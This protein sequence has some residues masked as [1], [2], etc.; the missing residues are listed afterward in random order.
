MREP[1]GSAGLF[2][3]LRSM[4]GSKHSD[5]T[6][7]AMKTMKEANLTALASRNPVL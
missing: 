6:A 4:D 7:C 3:C 5:G 2:C 1:G